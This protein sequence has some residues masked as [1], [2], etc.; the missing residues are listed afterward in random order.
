MAAASK[1]ALPV[2]WRISFPPLW[3]RGRMSM[4]PRCGA[5]RLESTEVASTE[6]QVPA[7]SGANLS[8]SFGVTRALMNVSIDVRP[9]EVRALVGR[10][11]AGKSTLVSILTGLTVADEGTVQ[12][13]GQAAPA[14]HAREKWQR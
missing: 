14:A 12:C 4:I 5:T 11:G 13:S 1:K 7:A 2:I 9:G 10:N 6:S 3:S 8:K